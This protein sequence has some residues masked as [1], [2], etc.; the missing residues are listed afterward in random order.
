[1]QAIGYSPNSLMV[2]GYE[3]GREDHEFN[4]RLG[5]FFLSVCIFIEYVS[6]F[7]QGAK[8]YPSE[9]FGQGSGD[10]VLDNVHC[11]A[12]YPKLTSCHTHS[13]HC[14]PTGKDVGVR[15]DGE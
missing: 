12:S 13:G 8:D 7:F 4:P 6:L 10:V 14:S 15:C 5:S 2:R 1:M 9:F 11:Y 3:P